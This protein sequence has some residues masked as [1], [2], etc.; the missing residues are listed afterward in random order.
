MQKPFAYLLRPGFRES[1]VLGAALENTPGAFEIDALSF[2]SF[3]FDPW[4]EKMSAYK[5]HQPTTNGSDLGADNILF[6]MRSGKP[7]R[8]LLTAVQGATARSSD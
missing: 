2:S 1:A 7:R 5:K 8:D 3:S 6:L 4:I